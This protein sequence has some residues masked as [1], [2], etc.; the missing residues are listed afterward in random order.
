MYSDTLITAFTRRHIVSAASSKK[1]DRGRT[2]K[3]CS[4]CRENNE[5]VSVNVSFCGQ[6][7]NSA[8]K[9][10][11]NSNSLSAVNAENVD[12]VLNYCRMYGTCI[13]KVQ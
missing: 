6:E 8:R 2:L 9:L 11:E 4:S 1:W 10:I 12:L 7:T 5:S 13:L 3:P